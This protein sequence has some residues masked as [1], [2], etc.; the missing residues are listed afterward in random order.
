MNSSPLVLGLQESCVLLQVAELLAG[1]KQQRLQLTQA[2]AAILQGNKTANTH[3][4]AWGSRQL[5]VT[6]HTS[7]DLQVSS[8]QSA[9]QHTGL[10]AAGWHGRFAKAANTHQQSCW[11]SAAAYMAPYQAT[12]V[13]PLN[14]VYVSRYS[15]ATHATY[16]TT[17][18]AL[19]CLTECRTRTLSVSACSKSSSAR[20]SARG[21][22][23]VE[24]S[25]KAQML[26]SLPFTRR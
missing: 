21:W 10:Q 20:C 13:P 16:I 14:M 12:M 18:Q 24:A 19:N 6:S 22:S 2:H 8:M 23:I 11:E 26:P 25:P 17:Y 1:L 5:K 7:K 15:L 4:Q 3:Q 9:D